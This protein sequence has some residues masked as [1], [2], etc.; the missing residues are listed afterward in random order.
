MKFMSSYFQI[1]LSV[2]F[3]ALVAFA[4]G[5]GRHKNE[6]HDN[7]PGGLITKP[8]TYKVASSK[9]IVAVWVDEEH[10]VRYSIAQSTGKMLI[11]SSER[12]SA[13]SSWLIYFDE[14]D[15]L[16]FESGDIGCSVAQKAA[17]GTYH[18]IP[19]TDQLELIRAMPVPFFER[20]PASIQ[21]RWASHRDG[22][23]R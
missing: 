9:Q 15:W 7:W 3:V 19:I 16:W 5:C 1:T 20:L 4:F 22:N 6:M 10:L 8:G 18:E 21:S 12:P 23:E 2:G 14:K 17:D 11:K 13:Y